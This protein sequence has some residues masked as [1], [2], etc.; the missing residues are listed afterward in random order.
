M[1]FDLSKKV[2]TRELLAEAIWKN[3]A[4][5]GNSPVSENDFQLFVII[6]KYGEKW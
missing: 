2:K 5:E 6:L 3:G 4:K 1:A